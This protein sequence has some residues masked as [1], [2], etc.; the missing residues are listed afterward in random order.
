M[1]AGLFASRFDLPEFILPRA[2]RTVILKHKLD[3]P[4]FQSLLTFSLTMTCKALHCLPTFHCNHIWYHL[5]S[6]SNYALC[7]TNSSLFI[8]Q[9][10]STCFSSFL[11]SSP[12]NVPH[13]HD[14]INVKSFKFFSLRYKYSLRKTFLIL[15]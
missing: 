3:H 2:A 9:L 14:R 1:L 13:V 12:L 15:K 4:Q 8:E 10:F 11:S 7:H 6:L 5:A